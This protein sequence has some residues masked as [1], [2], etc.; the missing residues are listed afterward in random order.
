[1][2]IGFFHFF[3]K[4]PLK[5]A[6]KPAT[7]QVEKQPKGATAM[8]S[9]DDKEKELVQEKPENIGFRAFFM[10]I[11]CILHQPGSDKLCPFLTDFLLI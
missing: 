1:M 7:I 8:N 6:Q 2:S 9:F 10:R 3:R 5:I 4:Q 11:C